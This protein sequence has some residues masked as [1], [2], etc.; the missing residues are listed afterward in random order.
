MRV[1]LINWSGHHNLGDDAMTQILLNEIPGAVN[2]GEHPTENAD[3]YVLGG[4]TLI[5]PLSLFPGR[6]P[7][8][9]RCIGISLG[10]SSNWDGEFADI[11]RR[12]KAIYVRDKF[13]YDKLQAHGIDCHL[14]V[15][16]VCFLYKNRPH[17]KREVWA[18]L[19]EPE[20]DTGHDVKGQISKARFE[21]L[22][23]EDVEYFA[24]CSKEDINT[25]SDAVLYIDA[26]K[27]ID[28]LSR[29]KIVYTTRLHANICAWV[30]E[31]PDIRP[32][33]YD[34]K[35]THFFDRVH[36]M[37]PRRAKSIISKHL[38]QVCQIINGSV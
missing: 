26:E 2:M 7:K 32:I 30:A 23:Y 24:M 11:L 28:A 9:E 8:P 4:G 1:E 36:E 3:W 33:T 12:F 14:S 6:V 10:V 27:L 35:I 5:A 38:K 31:C 18:N 17:V 37:T 34:P 13:S 25:Y 16:L 15:D 21:L 20:F 22:D 29:A 19:M